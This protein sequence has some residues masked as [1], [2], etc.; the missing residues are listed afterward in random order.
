VQSAT[1]NCG[2]LILILSPS[3]PYSLHPPARQ[4]PLPPPFSFLYVCTPGGTFRWA[5]SVTKLRSCQTVSLPFHSASCSFLCMTFAY[6]SLLYL[7]VVD[8]IPQWVSF[9]F[10][11]H[12]QQRLNNLPPWKRTKKNYFFSVKYLGLF[13]ARNSSLRLSS[14]HLS[15]FCFPLSRR[16]SH[17]LFQV[18]IYSIFSLHVFRNALHGLRKLFGRYKAL[19]ILS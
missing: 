19:F 8:V 9:Q 14:L 11:H 5:G 17:T 2:V 10:S 4:T 7:I 12:V 16:D 18:H 13:L 6:I 1:V 3:L 15:L